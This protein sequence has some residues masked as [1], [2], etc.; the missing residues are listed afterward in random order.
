[1]SEGNNL[2]AC[3]TN[4][5]SWGYFYFRQSGESFDEGFQ[6]VPVN[7]RISSKRKRAFFGL[8]AGITGGWTSL[9]DG[10]T[11]IGWQVKGLESRCSST[12]T[13]ACGSSS[14]TSASDR[15]GRKCLPTVSKPAKHAQTSQ[16]QFYVAYAI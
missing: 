13:T 6:S 11:L 8:L 4:Y 3:V 5:V 15:S 7:W 1:V 12:N 10:K 9:F 16:G 2:V 14:K